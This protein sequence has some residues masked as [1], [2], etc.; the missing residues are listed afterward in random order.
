MMRKLF[1]HEFIATGRIMGPLYAVVAVLSGYLLISYFTGAKSGAEEMSAPFLAAFVLVMIAF[2]NFLFTTVVMVSNFQKSLYGDQGYLSFT[3]PV[4]S[5]SLLLSK[6]L[7]STIWYILAV[8]CFVVSGFFFLYAAEEAAGEEMMA[9][10]ES[11][12]PLL[13]SG[14]T[15]ATII[16]AFALSLVFLFLQLLIIPNTIYLAISVA[17][18]RL[19]QKRHLLWTIIFTI[20]FDAVVMKI[21][22]VLSSN[23][24]FGFGV[25]E[26]S[27]TLITSIEELAVNASYTD[28]VQPIASVIVSIGL[29][30]ATRYVMHKKVNIR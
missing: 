8:V 22:E 12:L 28:M 15:L 30:I 9:M 17:N 11:F 18:T 10:I 2:C 25:T 1:K 27:I 29:F 3:L 26:G 14:K 13:L 4:K 16:T 20:G 19:F 21:I 6:V 23:I 24:I 7:V 5:T